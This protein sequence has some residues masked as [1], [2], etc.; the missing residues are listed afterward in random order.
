MELFIYKSD[1][2]HFY[3]VYEYFKVFLCKKVLELYHDLIRVEPPQGFNTNQ[4]M[5]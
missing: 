2:Y 1:L 5:I 3:K 4:T